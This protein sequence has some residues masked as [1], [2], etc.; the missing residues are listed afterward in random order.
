MTAARER[1]LALLRDGPPAYRR[2]DRARGGRERRRVVSG[3]GHSR[4]HRGRCLCLNWPPS[5]CPMCSAPGR[6]SPRPS[7]PAAT[8]LREAVADRAFSVAVLDGVTG[9][10]KTEVYFEALA[11]A[12][13][14]G[15]QVLVMLPEIALGA[16]WLA[17]FRAPLRRG[18]GGLAFRAGGAAAAR[19]PGAPS[20]RA[21]RRW[22]WARDPRSGSRSAASA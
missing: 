7:R 14:A 1:V 11:A 22:W 20:P 12:V 17:R 21:G 16:Q 5:A 19:G 9:A 15:L 8:T 6:S 13:G 3:P 2:R 10:G 4:R 18:A